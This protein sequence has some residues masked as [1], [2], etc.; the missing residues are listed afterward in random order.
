MHILFKKL[1]DTKIR[2]VVSRD[3]K[4]LGMEMNEWFWRFFFFFNLNKLNFKVLNRLE[5]PKLK[6]DI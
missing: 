6:G 5:E 1:I 4:G 2:L 3:R